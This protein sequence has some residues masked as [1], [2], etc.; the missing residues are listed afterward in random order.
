MTARIGVAGTGWWCTRAHLP[1]IEA[2]PAAE[3]TAVADPNEQNRRRASERFSPAAEYSDFREML[4]NETL[5][6]A[7]VATQHAFHYEVAAECLRKGLHVLVEKPMVLSSE[8]ASDLLRLASEAGREIIVGYPWNYT[9]QTN[10]VREWIGEGEIGDLLYVHSLFASVVWELYR[11]DVD[12]VAEVM[13]YPV[14]PTGQSTYSDPAIAGGGQGVTQIT[15]SAA[16]LLHMTG[17]APMEVFALMANHGLDVDL[18][19][20]MSVRF[21]GGCLGTI[22][23]TG[24]TVRTQPEILECRIYGSRGHILF[25]VMNEKLSL[26]RQDGSV[27]APA[28]ASGADSEFFFSSSYP[29]DAPL[30]NLVEIVTKGATSRSPGILG[31]RVVSLLEAAYRSAQTGQPEQVPEITS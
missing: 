24:S 3:L 10:S 23:S 6:A 28:P 30:N 27:V 5:D 7:V 9:A 26:H 12:V 18:V 21:E 1:A 19:N 13:G 8:H 22:G 16:H 14:N 17:L 25:D 20:A 15:H 11:G 29:E 2:N 4:A 31:A